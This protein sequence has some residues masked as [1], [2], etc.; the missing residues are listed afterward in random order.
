LI[1]SKK[2]GYLKRL[3]ETFEVFDSEAVLLV[4]SVKDPR[5]YGVIIGEEIEDGLYRV[6]Q[7]I[8]K[9]EVPPSNLAVVAIYIFSSRI[10][11]SLRHT[12]FDDRSE[13][14]LT[15][16]IQRLVRN[17]LS[18]Y[19]VKL[20]QGEKRIEIGTPDTY[21]KAMKTTFRYLP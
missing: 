17:G 1:L 13:L 11:E 9:P 19:A 12:E 6:K 8:E 21:W 2:K 5:S 16:A 3:I 18:V 7:I 14:Q 10:F 20:K 15:N 4:E